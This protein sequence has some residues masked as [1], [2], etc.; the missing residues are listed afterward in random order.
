[1][2]STNRYGQDQTAQAGDMPP[3]G[4]SGERGDRPSWF[5]EQLAAAVLPHLG[6]AIMGDDFQMPRTMFSVFSREIRD[7][8][9]LHHFQEAGML[10]LRI[11]GFDAK[12]LQRDI[13]FFPP[14]K[15]IDPDMP[16]SDGVADLQPGPITPLSPQWVLRTRWDMDASG[17]FGPAPGGNPAQRERLKIMV[18]LDD[19]LIRFLP[20]TSPL[21]AANAKS[22]KL[23]FN[24]EKG[25]SAAGKPWASFW[26]IRD[27]N[28]NDPS[29]GAFNI[30]LL[31]TDRLDA[32]FAV[33]IIIDPAVTNRG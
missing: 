9:D 12:Q 19:P 4:Y 20:G 31:A 7:R 11:S 5:V 15:T 22:T 26:L 2:S 24:L 14:P 16:D 32:D 33:P 6:H 8:A 21:L 17:Y 10:R 25:V 28:P 13:L 18:V 23:M 1:M 30:A 27:T 29:T 3:I